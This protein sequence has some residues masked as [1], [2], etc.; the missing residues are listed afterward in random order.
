[1][2]NL[3]T[4]AKNPSGSEESNPNAT[5]S[6]VSSPNNNKF[7]GCVEAVTS[8]PTKPIKSRNLSVHVVNLN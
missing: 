7:N 2:A 6:P 4:A 3:S 8:A 1:M 5:N